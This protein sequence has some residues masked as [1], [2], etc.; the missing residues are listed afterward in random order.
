VTMFKC[1]LL[2]VD[3]EPYIL[4]TLAA[5]LSNEFDVLTADSAEA[6]MK[7]LQAREV[8]IVLSDQRMPR[9][10]GVQL[11][12]WTRQHAPKTVRLLMTGFAELEEA[13]EALAR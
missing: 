9:M 8:D 4:S 13:V 3:D 7:I 5:L 11:L 12:E 10:N 2:V 1:S 6:G